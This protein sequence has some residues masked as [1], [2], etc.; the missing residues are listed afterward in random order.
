MHD[1]NCCGSCQNHK[2]FHQRPMKCGK[3]IWHMLMGS[4]NHHVTFQTRICFQIYVLRFPHIRA[5]HLQLY[6]FKPNLLT[7]IFKSFSST[8]VPTY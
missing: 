6:H 5:T 7:Y 4:Q 8:N 1:T 3:L 2:C